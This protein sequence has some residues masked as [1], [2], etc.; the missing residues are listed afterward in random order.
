M[1]ITAEYIKTNYLILLVKLFI[2]GLFVLSI[3]QAK[4]R[5]SNY[6]EAVGKTGREYGS[7]LFFS[8]EISYYRPSILLLV[9]IIGIFI[10][11]KIGWIVIQAYFYFLLSNLFF[12]L[13]FAE[14][15][16]SFSILVNIAVS[17]LIVLAIILL[18]RRSICEGF[19]GFTKKEFMSR[20][21]IASIVGLLMTFA[22]IKMKTL[23]F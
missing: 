21:I 5:S 11:K 6:W 13:S 23:P 22:L 17:L 1:K 8:R 10:N 12:S 2:L 14:N 3:I 4:I 7:F 19:Y 9:P 15:T 18:N 16:Y 20:N